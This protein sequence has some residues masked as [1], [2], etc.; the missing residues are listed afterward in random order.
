MTHRAFGKEMASKDQRGKVNKQRENP[1][2]FLS[3]CIEKVD[4]SHLFFFILIALRFLYLI[5]SG[6]LE[7]KFLVKIPIDVIL[8]KFVSK[9]R[10]PINKGS[11]FL[12]SFVRIK[13]KYLEPFT[14]GLLQ[15]NYSI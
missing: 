15:V 7:A 5:T 13:G 9:C 8:T 10:K 4:E 11:Q 1:F 6:F 2:F 14:G 12:L 3:F